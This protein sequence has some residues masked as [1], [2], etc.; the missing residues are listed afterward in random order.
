MTQ[1]TWSVSEPQKLSFEEPVAE[2][3]VRVVNGAV[4]VVGA[5]PADPGGPDGTG[6][7]TARL[8]VSQVAG[9]PLRVTL[10]D[11]VLTVAY[12][13]LPWTSFKNWFDR[14]GWQRTAVVSSPCPQAPASRSARSPRAPWSP[15]SPAPPRSAPSAGT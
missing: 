13:D 9:P 2:L 11:G 6:P 1:S 12:E 10:A 3:S 15:G 14:D 5:E 8:E 7:G 4:N